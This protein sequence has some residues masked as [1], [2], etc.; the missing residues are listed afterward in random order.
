MTKAHRYPG[1]VVLAALG[2]ALLVLVA[3]L[4]GCGSD[5]TSGS[6]GKG[7]GDSS[8]FPR[9]VTIDGA[10]VHLDALPQSIVVLSPSLTETVYGVGAGDQVKAVDKLSDYPKDAP[11]TDL[12]A[13][14]P[15]A[16]SIASYSPDLVL[17][18]DDQDGIVEA[19]A[20]LKIPTAVLPAPKTLD[21]AYEQFR[22]VGELTGHDKQAAA[23]AKKVE[24]TIDTTVK[25]TPKPSTPLTYYW[26]L[27]NTGYT[28]TS[29]TFVGSILSKF[30]LKNIADKAPN[31]AGGYPQ[32]SME[33]IIDSDPD[34]IFLA[35]SQCCGQNATTVKA[36][37][38]WDVT[39][40]VKEGNVISVNDDIASRWGPRIA[41]LAKEV[42]AAIKDAS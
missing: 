33:Y 7:S 27:D 6:S 36:R 9:D 15:K 20:K 41:D 37:P 10:K 35:D 38:G 13:Y 26:E 32:L 23:L 5:S 16:E 34:L 42:G 30:G 11:V 14:A 8:E 29:D 18:A 2:T 17:T 22:Q 21:D 39:R 40:A 25:D 3:L 31:A 24:T 4:A 19:L 28:V 12:D 1:R